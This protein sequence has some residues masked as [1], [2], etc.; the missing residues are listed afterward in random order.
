MPA[1]VCNII[2]VCVFKF[3]NKEPLYLMLRRSRTDTLY[4]DAWQIVTGSIETGETAVQGA[5]RELQEETGYIPVKFWAV[6]HVNTFYSAQY[7]TI[8][9]T[10][11][12]AAQV[13]PAV[14]I[15]LSQ[16]H[17]QYGWYTVDHAKAKSVWPGQVHA[18]DII[19][20]YIVRGKEAS[21]FSEI[22]L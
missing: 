11:V 17:S 10:V 12:F 14:E 2:E 3:E 19:H 18:L 8:N 5:L 15:V 7:D 4:P 9:H 22:T 13:D 1:I 6:P 21:S 16:E 20:D